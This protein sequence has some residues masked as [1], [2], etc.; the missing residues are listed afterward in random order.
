[1]KIYRVK[2]HV[3]FNGH[4]DIEAESP[5][6]ASAEVEEYTDYGLVNRDA[7]HDGVFIDGVQE[8]KD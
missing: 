7:W 3:Q 5:E 6:E 4:V 2:Y 1:V 8:Q